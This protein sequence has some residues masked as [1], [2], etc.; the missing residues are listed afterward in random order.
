MLLVDL[1]SFVFA[2]A[3]RA[4]TLVRAFSS[5]LARG[6]SR[7]RVRLVA[8]GLRPA[9]ARPTVV[10]PAFTRLAAS[11]PRP[12]PPGRQLSAALEL[13]STSAP[14]SALFRGR[15][16]GLLCACLLAFAAL[17]PHLVSRPRKDVKLRPLGAAS[18]TH[19]ATY[20]AVASNPVNDRCRRLR[21]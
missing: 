19:P 21:R 15:E 8:A 3:L 10:A 18:I 12:H 7:T 2:R 13:A 20:S 9:C 4:P 11:P 16:T 6:Y 17:A 14:R 5:P 1:Q